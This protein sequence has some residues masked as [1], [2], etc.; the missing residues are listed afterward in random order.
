MKFAATTIF[1]ISLTLSVVFGQGEEL[2]PDTV[3]NPQERGF[4]ELKTDAE[5]HYSNKSFTLAHEVYKRIQILELTAEEKRWTKFRLAD[6]QWRAHA[7]SGRQEPGR[8]PESRRELENL[9]RELDEL[10]GP[11]PALWA[12]VEESLGDSLWSRQPFNNWGRAWTHYMLVLDWLA[13][14]KDL[15]TARPRYLKIVWKAVGIPDSGGPRRHY[16][17]WL[18]N[19]LPLEII[20]NAL[21]IAETPVDRAHAHYLLAMTLRRQGGRPQMQARVA[22][23][24]ASAVELGERSVWYDDALF[25]YARWSSLG[26]LLTYDENG[27]Q[28][29]EP[30]YEKALLLYRR[31]LNEYD[32]GETGYYHTARNAIES[33]VK[34]YVNVFVTHAYQPGSEPQINLR[35]RNVDKIKVSLFAVDL[36][37]AVRFNQPKKRALHS[38]IDS[39]DTRAM[40][41]WHSFTL[42]KEAKRPHYPLT[43][44]YRLSMEIPAGAYVV[45]ADGGTGLTRSRDILLVTDAALVLKSTE[46]EV[47]AYFCDSFTGEPLKEAEVVLWENGYDGRNWHSRRKAGITDSDGLALFQ[48]SGKLERREYFAAARHEDRQAFALSQGYYYGMRQDFQW[49]VY[50]YT[51]RPAYR[52]GSTAQWKIITRQHDA[53]SYR[54]PTDEQIQF[55][56]IDPR[57]QKV[58]EGILRLN[59]YGAAWGETAFNEEMPLG[60]YHIQFARNSNQESIGQAQLFRLEEYK[61]PEFKVEIGIARGEGSAVEVFRLGDT[62]TGEI[63]ADYYFGGPVPNAQIELVIYQ[64]PFYH[65]WAPPRDYDW[66]YAEQDNQN[67]YRNFGYGGPG[68]VIKRETLQTDST[69]AAT[70]TFETPQSS[71]NDYQYTV[72]ARVTDASRREITASKTLKV[73]RQSYYVYLKPEHQIYQPGDTAE[74]AIRTMDANS[75][76]V[77]AEGRLRLTREYWRE[78]WI[79]D[80]GREISSQQMEELREKSSRRFS[81]GASAGDYHLKEKGYKVEEIEVTSLA[82]DEKGEAIYRISVPREGY[83]KVAW[84]SR[85]EIGPPIKAD[86]AFWS[87]RE[88]DTEIGYRPGGVSIVVDKDSFRVGEKAPVMIS[89]PASGR[90]VLFTVGA[91]HLQSYQILRLDGTVKL[92]HLDIGDEHIPNTFLEALMVSGHEMFMEQKE[93]VVPPEKNFLQIEVSADAEGYQPGEKGSYSIRATDWQ[94]EPVSAEISLGLVDDA[95]YYIQSELASD[96]RQFFYGEKRGYSIQTASTFNQK[97]YFRIMEVDEKD[98]DANANTAAGSRFRI[99]ESVTYDRGGQM[100]LERGSFHL[101]EFSVSDQSAIA[102]EAS[103]Q[104]SREEPVVQ[105]R[106]DFRETVFWQPDLLTDENGLAKVEVTFPDSLTTWR[107]TARAVSQK[108]RFGTASDTRQTRLPLIASLQA[109]R[110]FVTGDRLLI[111]GVFH[112][113]TSVPMPLEALL[114]TD[115]GLEILERPSGATSIP[116]NSQTRLDW[117][118]TPVFPGEVRIKLTGKSRNFA[119]AME[120]TYPVYEHGIEKFTGKSGRLKGDAVTVSLNIPAERKKASTVFS[121][122]ATPSLAVAMLDALPYLIGYPY[123]C[124]EQTLSRFLPSVLVTKTLT[125]LNLEPADIAGKMFGGLEK[126][127]ADAAHRRGPRDLSQLSK[128]VKGGLERL[129]DFQ[130]ADGGW[131]W[132]KKGNTDPYMSAYV[133][134]G[135][136]LAGQAGVEVK[137]STLKRARSYLEKALVE[138]EFAYDVQAWMLHALAVRFSDAEDKR[139]SR[140]EASAFLNLM[141]N[142][143][144]LNSFTRALLA[145]AAWH[146]GFEEEA[147]LLAQNL[148]DGVKIDESPD[149]SILLTQNG[150][151]SPAV[152][153]TAHWGESGVFW[154]WSD[155]GV[156]ATSFALMALLAIE[157]ESD[158]I[159]PVMNWLVKNRRGGHWS[160]TRDSAIALLALNQYLEMTKE[161]ESDLTYEIRVNG[162]VLAEGQTGSGNW[163]AGQSNWQVPHEWLL[164]GGNE[165][166][167]RRLSGQGSLYFSAQAEFFSLEEPVPAA[168]N[169]IYVRRDYHRLRSV[170][171]LLK[172]FVEEKMPINDGDSLQSGDRIEVVLTIE[173]KNDYEYLIFEDLKPA[174]LEAVQIRSG[175]ALYA[176]EIKAAAV[177]SDAAEESERLSGKRRWV[178]QELRD[179]KMA[180]FIDKLPEGY[181]EIRYRLRAETPGEFHALPVLGHAM[182]VPEI[183]ANGAEIRLTV[184]EE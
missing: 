155:G 116:A 17:G 172:G 121:V 140:L 77:P 154:R 19:A 69:G 18:G 99:A 113:N 60:P 177:N 51:D 95:V 130:H 54:V 49:R 115:G 125:G 2:L 6:S 34:P 150:E 157:P 53:D 135:L 109:P 23:E 29:L 129:Y 38:W 36:N 61:L 25:Q 108:S 89:T 4:A 37:E 46:Y 92:L 67:R 22:E 122:Q 15:E 181:W 88:G 3:A 146:F 41:P 40:E 75:R 102:P 136:T 145:L 104:Q 119:D 141:R 138:A 134:W 180:L 44:Q 73:T 87:S 48:L 152:M 178:Y 100:A 143:E 161:L 14:S 123:G 57:G 174:G 127:Y 142:R 10:E 91:A 21:R 106:A 147:G 118:V 74:I 159:E 79:D 175:E 43:E 71:E 85:E 133:V 167:I 137:K 132:W 24:F 160:N 169:E 50:A 56:I 70:F 16:R 63:Q 32:E 96:I 65:W 166:E 170:P 68:A 97:P 52:P 76:P 165:V 149:Q 33:I 124:T 117:L 184:E 7:A 8:I 5:A 98:F 156:E 114:E 26:G 13:G 182:Y 112:N 72:E 45:E 131:G 39:I 110:F 55:T 164:D 168:G 107:A 139:P 163:L 31:I 105:V 120:K 183:R 94:G 93:I 148:R 90:T 62:V 101:S 162:H 78:I 111:S 176:S 126:E 20:E 80:G 173:G 11:P 1:W 59:A 144:Q 64:R 153:A 42:D 83:F 86:T 84:V 82:T 179:R 158:L 81:F 66:L 27:D 128:M 9:A 35:W 58:D 103:M 171:T 12:D 47:L 151:T 30:D 28:R